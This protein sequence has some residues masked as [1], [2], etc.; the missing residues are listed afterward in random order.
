MLDVDLLTEQVEVYEP[1]KV[2]VLSVHSDGD[3]L[4]ALVS[5]SGGTVSLLLVKQ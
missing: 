2:I 5:V 1:E 3:R 4:Y